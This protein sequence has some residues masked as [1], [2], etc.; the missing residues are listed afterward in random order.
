MWVLTVTC[1]ALLDS[2]IQT[3]ITTMSSLNPVTAKQPSAPFTSI[4]VGFLS[5]ELETV[6]QWFSCVHINQMALKKHKEE[7]YI[8]GECL[9]SQF[10][11]KGKLFFLVRLSHVKRKRGNNPLKLY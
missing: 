7:M 9:V 10:S 6:E 8:S 5:D 2:S 3:T 1:S 4:T 11:V